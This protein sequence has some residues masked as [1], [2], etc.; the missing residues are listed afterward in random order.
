MVI[1]FN[2][3]YTAKPWSEGDMDRY[4]LGGTEKCVALIARE[5]ANGTRANI[6]GAEVYVVGQV[7]ENN[8]EDSPRYVRYENLHLIPKK[9]DLLVGVNYINYLVYFRDFEVKK[10]F[11]W[12]HNTEFYPWYKGEALDPNV[13]HLN[14]HKI[15]KVVALTEWHKQAISER[16]NVDLE[17]IITIP[18]PVNSEAFLPVQKENKI[19][20]SFIY[21][22]H[23]E[24]G[25]T[26][27]IE[28]WPHILESLPDATL[29]IATPSYGMDYF[30][31]HFLH[32]VMPMKNVT[33]YG[34]LGQQDLYAL[35]AKC[36]IWWYPSD[37]EETFCLTAVEMVSHGVIPATRM[38][39]SLQNVLQGLN[40]ETWQEAVEIFDKWKQT[41]VK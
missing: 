21:T 15:D 4:G 41:L 36:A 23:A 20:H 5:L 38:T 39:A 33:F 6:A 2:V 18:N 25:L 13:Y 3:G 10:N 27:I 29:H 14:H 31:D 7:H 32:K 34:S 35:M 40:V 28:E 19:P 26:N 8:P 16:F 24:R 11:F 17:R 22:S 9:I 37:Y 1:V 12:I 30:N